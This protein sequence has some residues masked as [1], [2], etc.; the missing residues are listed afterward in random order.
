MT[1]EKFWKSSSPF[2]TGDI[3]KKS[4]IIS[5]ISVKLWPIQ[6][7]EIYKRALKSIVVHISILSQTS[8][9]RKRGR[10]Y[11]SRATK[12]RVQPIRTFLPFTQSYQNHCQTCRHLG[13]ARASSLPSPP[14]KY[15]LF[16]GNSSSL[17]KFR[18][19][20]VQSG[21]SEGSLTR[22]CYF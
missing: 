19:W 17:K 9:D 7:L 2:I 12:A 22:T 18:R 11:H 14:Q 20:A 1:A 4:K 16:V 6:S 5:S 21:G 13:Q 10:P 15:L 3:C 8:E